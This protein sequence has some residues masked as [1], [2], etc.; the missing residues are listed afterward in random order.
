VPS[1]AGAAAAE[2]ALWKDVGPFALPAGAFLVPVELLSLSHGAMHEARSGPGRSDLTP[3]REGVLMPAYAGTLSNVPTPADAAYVARVVAR[4]ELTLRF[5]HARG[6]LHGDVKPSNVFLDFAGDAWLGDFGTSIPTAAAAAGDFA[7][8]TAAYQSED[9][10]VTREP[11]R[12]DLIGLA[13]AAL[14]LL[15]LLKPASAPWAAASL[16]ARVRASAFSGL[17]DLTVGKLTGLPTTQCFISKMRFK[18]CSGTW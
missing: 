17:G 5:L 6:W 11:L 13:A 18:D 14:E 1:H 4:L 10:D 3:L 9:V 15:G 16:M 8:G 2:C 7:G 12:F